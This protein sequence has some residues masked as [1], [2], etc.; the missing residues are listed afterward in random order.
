[1]EVPGLGVESE[2]RLRAT[3]QP[4]LHQILNLLSKARDQTCILRDT[5]SHPLSHDRNNH[6]QANCN[7]LVAFFPVFLL[8]WLSVFVS[9]D[10]FFSLEKVVTSESGSPGVQF[11]FLITQ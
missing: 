10:P 2:L 1:M 8:T 9:S 11:F 7:S 4:W 5:M 3:P 6:H